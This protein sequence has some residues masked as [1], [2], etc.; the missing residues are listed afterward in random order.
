MFI[1]IFYMYI[2][3]LFVVFKILVSSVSN[4]DDSSS[5]VFFIVHNPEN[6]VAWKALQPD[7]IKEGKRAMDLPSEVPP[8]KINVKLMTY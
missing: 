1:F 7:F 5:S 2:Y 4:M 6:G 3:Q 8:G